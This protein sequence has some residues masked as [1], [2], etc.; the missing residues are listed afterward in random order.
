MDFNIAT[1]YPVADVP[2]IQRIV[3][4]GAAVALVVGLTGWGLER[5]RFGASDESARRRVE[6]ELR[7]RI[8]AGATTLAAI[9]A[10]VTAK[11]EAMRR[12]PLDRAAVKLLFDIARGALPADEAGHTGITIYDADAAPLAWAGRVS[13]LPKETVEGPSTLLVGPGALGPRL[14]RLDPILLAAG[15]PRVAAIVVEPAL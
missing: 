14:V 4:A 13:D 5:A 9:A 3:R 10:R 11:S 6:V 7:Q 1:V 2:F 12:T 15:G 8:D